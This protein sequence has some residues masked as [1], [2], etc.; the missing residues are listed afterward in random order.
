[1]QCSK[2]WHCVEVGENFNRQLAKPEYHYGFKLLTLYQLNS[3]APPYSHD[4]KCN[5]I[6]AAHSRTIQFVNTRQQCE[7]LIY[8]IGIKFYA[9]LSRSKEVFH[10]DKFS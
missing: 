6:A 8:L 4:L 9:L 1:M 3:W 5:F 10:L 7:I 2:T